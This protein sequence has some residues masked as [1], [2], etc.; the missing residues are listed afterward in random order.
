MA[1]NSSGPIRLAG[2]TLGESVELELGG[3]GTTTISLNDATVRRLIGSASGTI[4]LGGALGQ[5]RFFEFSRTI[6]SD[7]ADYNLY[8]D[9]A[10]NGWNQIKEVKVT[11]TNNAW[12]YASSTSSYALNISSMPVNSVITVVNNSY[13]VGAGGYGGGGN[14]G[15]GNNTNTAYPGYAPGTGGNAMYI[16]SAITMYNNNF[17]SGGGGGG[18]GAIG[19]N[20]GGKVRYPVGGQGGGGGQGYVGGAAGP[21][22]TNDAGRPGAAGGAGTISAP[23]GPN[24]GGWGADGGSTSYT[25]GGTRGY[26]VI[27]IGNVTWA[28]T[29]TSLGYS[30]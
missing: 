28:A 10:N 27:G 2:T 23:G 25:G 26:Y 15:S 14:G 13:I 1:L 3:D 20:T 4:S 6:S 12:L 22:G 18:A 30:A 11:L 21:G 16:A 9:M 5:A 7:T 29:G 24:G 17:I 19:G 8:N